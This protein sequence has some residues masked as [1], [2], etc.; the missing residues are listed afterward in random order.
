MPGTY[1]EIVAAHASAQ[2]AANLLT[3]AITPTSPDNRWMS[4][5]SFLGEMCPEIQL[6][7]PCEE[8]ADMDADG[9][10]PVYV[11]PGAY[12]MKA[13]C[14]NLAVDT[15]IAGARLLR[16][17]EAVASYAAA[18]ELWTGEGTIASPF[19]VAAP[20]GATHNPYLRDGNATVLTGAGNVMDAI[21]YLEQE[22]RHRTGGQKVYLHVPIRVLTRVAAQLQR[23][24]NEIRTFTDAVVIADAGYTGQGAGAASGVWAYA[25]GPVIAMLGPV[26]EVDELPFTVDRRT[27]RR[28]VWADRM[29][30]ASFDPCCQLAIQV[31]AAT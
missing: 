6:F 16:M 2:T 10:E 4:G 3:S 12:R 27:N 24:G 30:A 19:P 14:S 5:F 9:S 20:S 15:A 11:Q 1:Q 25:T 18:R 31:P 28:T 13:E 21:G 29:F 22:A 8:P 26:A 23:V 17:T 7:G